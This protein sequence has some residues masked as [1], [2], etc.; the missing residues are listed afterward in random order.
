ML[1][2]YQ[3]DA[4]GGLAS[5]DEIGRNTWVHLIAPTEAEIERVVSTLGVPR[6]FLLDPLDVDERPRVEKDEA[7]VLI[8]LS[9]PY[10]TGDD[11]VP[12]R[13]VPVGVIHTPDVLVTVCRMDHPIFHPFRSGQVKGFYTH[14]KTRFTLQLMNHIARHY[15]RDLNDL[16]GRIA[17]AEAALQRSMRNR[18]VYILLN[19]NKSLVYF[20]TALRVNRGVMQ[21]LTRETYMKMYEDDEELLQD[22]IV[23]MQQALDASDIH[24]ENLSNLMDA[25]AAIIQNNVNTVLKIL[26]ALTIILAIP[27]MIA[28]IYGMNV[29]LPYQDSPYAFPVLMGL[30]LVIGLS[31]GWA[32]YRMRLF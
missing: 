32:F 6:D 8:I 17:E 21:K 25:Y 30:A 10:P 15:L 12:Y 4:Q 14:M 31:T 28:S 3:S 29:P 11:P 7:G 18:E 20:T 9:V 22:A 16:N 1:T 24:S 2:I 27:T 26:T 19:I 13:T 23:E 5:V